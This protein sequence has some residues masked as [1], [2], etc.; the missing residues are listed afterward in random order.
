MNLKQQTLASEVSVKGIGLHTGAEVTLTFCPAEADQGIKFQRIDLKGEPIIEAVADNVV[1]TSRSTTLG[2]EDAKVSTVEHVLSALGGLQIDN[3]LIK[4][5][6][7]EIPIMDGSALPF[8]EAFEEAGIKEQGAVREYFD[9]PKTI[10]YVEEDRGVELTA[11]PLDGYRITT[12]IDYQSP[13]LPPQQVTLGTIEDYKENFASSRTFCFF[14]EIEPLFKAGLIKGGDVDNAIVIVDHEVSKEELDEVSSMLGKPHLE[15]KEEGTLNNV[16]LRYKDEASRHKLLDV[17]GDLMLVGKPLRGQIIAS[18]PGHKANVELAKAIR[19]EMIKAQ[20]K[21]SYTPELPTDDVLWDTQ[22]VYDALPHEYPFKLV[23]RITYLDDS[24]VVGLKNVT[25][26]EPVFTGHFPGNPVFPGVLI[27][28]TIAQVGGIF[29][30]SKTD[31]PGGYWTFFLG[32]DKCKF[33]QQVVPGDQMVIRCDQLRPINRG[34]IN[35]IGRAYVNDVLVC[36]AE[37][38]ARI[39][40]KEG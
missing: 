6:G 22:R 27:L 32:I 16:E 17:V 2:V 13:V 29:A 11:M 28:E 18:R 10:S 38:L 1:D 15:V 25:I 20:K 3:V 24:S 19:K 21:A 39:V 33:R 14:R 4:L 31:D 34:L 35:M 40:K 36:E 12:M 5:D 37:M 9:I 26:N 23:D 7:E 30:L 8:V